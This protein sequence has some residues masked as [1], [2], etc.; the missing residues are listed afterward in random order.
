LTLAPI[1]KPLN[2]ITGLTLLSIKLVALHGTYYNIGMY[3]SQ[4]FH[5]L[6]LVDHDELLCHISYTEMECPS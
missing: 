5:L 1:T 3:Q 2:S 6:L 4:T